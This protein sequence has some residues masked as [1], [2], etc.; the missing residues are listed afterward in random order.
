MA[1]AVRLGI[2]RLVSKVGRRPIHIIAYSTGAA[3]A[4]DFT[5]NAMDGIA[6][7]VPASLVLISP[8]I[9]IHAAG[10][11]AGW[12]AKLAV[13]PG[14]ERLAWLDIGRGPCDAKLGIPTPSQGVSCAIIL[15]PFGC[16]FGKSARHSNYR[17]IGPRLSS[18]CSSPQ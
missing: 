5:L 11:L 9:G 6:S 13:L 10:A 12:K 8:A 1:A 2:K 18:N 4:L 15:R 7:S 14:L 3:L 17:V 16:G